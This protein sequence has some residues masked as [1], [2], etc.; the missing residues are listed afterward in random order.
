MTMAEAEGTTE[1]LSDLRREID[2]LDEELVRL[3]ASRLRVVQRVVKVKARDGLPANIPERV[4][5]VVAAARHRARAEG[6]PP[7]LAELLWREMVSWII[8]Y[9]DRH[10][11]KD[12]QG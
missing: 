8:A 10:L 9:E 11:A 1:T 5:E 6:L 3:L 12:G 7:E 2:A 4:E